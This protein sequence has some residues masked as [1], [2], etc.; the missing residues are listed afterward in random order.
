MKCAKRSKQLYFYSHSK[1]GDDGYGT[2][3]YESLE[4]GY[5]VPVHVVVLDV[6]HSKCQ[7]LTSPFDFV[8]FD[9]LEPGESALSACLL[10]D[11][12]DVVYAGDVSSDDVCPSGFFTLLYDNNCDEGMVDVVG[13]PSCDDDVSGIFCKAELFKE[14][15]CE[16]GISKLM[17]SNG[18]SF[19]LYAEKYTEHALVV[20]YN[21]N[22][23][24]M[25]LVPGGG[26]L[27]I[28]FNDVV[29]HAVE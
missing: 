17:T 6:N 2:V 13:V 27:N 5:I 15:L 20:Q 28:K 9:V 11:Q 22:K 16:I 23:C 7:I 25:K 21:D 18:Y 26:E 4:Y 12:I 3:F 19:Q 14:Q 1:E 24:Y 8:Y 10:S 29:Y